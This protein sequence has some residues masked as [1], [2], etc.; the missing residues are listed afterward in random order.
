M[1]YLRPILF[2]TTLL[3]LSAC[4]SFSLDKERAAEQRKQE[5]CGE[6]GTRDLPHCTGSLEPEPAE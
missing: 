4:S 6:I 2:A 1:K 5:L 3:T